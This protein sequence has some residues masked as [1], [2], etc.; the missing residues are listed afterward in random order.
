VED[1]PIVIIKKKRKK[2]KKRREI[3][4]DTDDLL[5]EVKER[6]MVRDVLTEPRY[7]RYWYM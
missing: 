5:R 7:L 1:M 3:E 2:R 4:I 6:W